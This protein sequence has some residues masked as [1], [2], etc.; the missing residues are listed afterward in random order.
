MAVMRRFEKWLVNSS[1]MDRMHARRLRKLLA[2]A[3]EV[4]G[5]ALEIGCGKG[6]TSFEI[7]QR[8][9]GVRLVA[10]DFDADQVQRAQDRVEGKAS[11]A[12]ANVSG[13]IVFEQ[14]DASELPF[15]DAM[16]DA[17]FAFDVHHHVERWKEALA[18]EYRVLKKGGRLFILDFG[19]IWSFPP[20]SWLME[21]EGRFTK[22][23]FLDGMRRVGFKIEKL[24]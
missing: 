5:R 2:A 3:P 17:A 7:V 11:K 15:K 14:A 1:I 4:R 12:L 9:K 8:F 18:E 20:L 23:E 10:T 24:D 13:R 22:Q 19:K 6:T 21:H 16:F